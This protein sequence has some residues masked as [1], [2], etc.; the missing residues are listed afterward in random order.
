MRKLSQALLYSSDEA[1][2][3]SPQKDSILLENSKT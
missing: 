1:L 3:E 2:T